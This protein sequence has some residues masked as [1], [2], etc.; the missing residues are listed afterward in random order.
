MAPKIFI[1]GEHGTT[2]LQIR[3][4]MAGRRDVELLSIPESERR[5][6]AMREDMLNDADIAIL[7]LP[8]DASKEAVHMVSGNNNVRVIDTSTAFRVNPSWAY[9][10]AE[11]DKEQAEKIKSAR[12]VA[13]PG[14]YPTGAIGLIR[15]LRAASILPDAYPVTVNAV[16]GYTGGG[17]QMIAQMEDQSRDDAIP[18]PHFLYGLTLTH[19]H[20]PEMKIHGLLDREPIFSP[21]VGKFP[22]GMI[23]Q[24]PLHLGHLAE[25]TTLENIHAAL[26]AHYAGQD[27]V[28]VVPLEESRK[29]PRIDAVELAGKD[30]MKLFV[31]GTPGAS[32][33]NLVA[34]LDNLGK[35]ASGAAVQ[36]MDLMLAS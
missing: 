3:T 8:D 7:C 14:C 33:V 23:V 11:M 27:I 15:P 26:V 35:G 28:T 29:L 10:F 34:L 13:N 31:F 21:S 19:K 32:Q 6:A 20:V 17:K 22:Q 16:S 36:N 24:V 12:F 5:N 1:D 9:G 18:A 4:R 30:T 2:G 25:G